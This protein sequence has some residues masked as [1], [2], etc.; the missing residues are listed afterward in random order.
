MGLFH[1]KRLEMAY[2]RMKTW[3]EEKLSCSNNIVITIPAEV[4]ECE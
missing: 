1:L 2:W 4:Q 3:R